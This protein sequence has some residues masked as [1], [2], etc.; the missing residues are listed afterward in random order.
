MLVP[1]FLVRGFVEAYTAGK[2][3]EWEAVEQR[4]RE[5]AA[6]EEEQQGTA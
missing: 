6:E 5:W 1:N 2:T 3:R 4:W